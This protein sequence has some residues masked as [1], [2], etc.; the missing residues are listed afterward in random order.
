MTAD[1]QRETTTLV[2]KLRTTIDGPEKFCTR[3]SEWWP[4]DREFF[5]AYPS[6]AAGLFYCCK[7]CYS[8]WLREHRAKK[9][10]AQ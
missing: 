6:G 2:P 10:V 9:K 5:H 7:A 4:A 8:E 1:L 3:C